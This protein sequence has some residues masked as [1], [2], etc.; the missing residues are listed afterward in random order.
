MNLGQ[1]LVDEDAV[2]PVIGIVLMVAI[3][4][5]LAAV[6]GTFVLGLGQSV[7]DNT[8]KVSWS[9]EYVDGDGDGSFAGTTPG[10]PDEVVITAEAGDT[11]ERTTEVKVGPN[12]ADK[13]G[14]G[15]D[16]D[17]SGSGFSLPIAS[18]NSVTVV[19]AGSD[20]SQSGQRMFVIYEPDKPAVRAIVGESKVPSG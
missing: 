5:I 3:T 1:L 2:S 13:N 17:G 19:E 6:I 4:V 11:I 16:Y 20:T 9:F 18:G 7:E 15:L 10:A 8:P 12:R 14:N